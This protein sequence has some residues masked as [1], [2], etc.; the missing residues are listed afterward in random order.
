M[1]YHRRDRAAHLPLSALTFSL[2]SALASAAAVAQEGVVE[3]P[4]RLVLEHIVVTGEKVERSLRD[5][6]SSV[7]VIGE[8]ALNSLHHYSVS[9]V[10]AEVPNVV[11]TTGTVPN[12]RGVAGNG[13]AGGFNS[14]TGGAKA[15][16]S[17]LIDGVAEPFVADLTGDSGIWDI[18]QIEV[19]RGPQSTSNGRNSIGGMIYIK[20]NDPSLGEWDG[21]ARMGYRDQE[22][23]VDSA[24]MLN[25]PLLE[26]TLAVRVTAEKLDAQTL[27]DTAGFAGNPPDY[28]PNAIDTW[29]LKTKLLWAPNADFSALLA[30]SGNNEQGDTGRVFYTAD[31]P[32]EYKRSFFRNI[33]TDSDTV[34]LRLDYRLS[35][36]LS[37]DILAAAM[38]YQWGFEGYEADPALEQDVLFDESNVTLD[39]RMNLGREGDT[40]TGFAGLF[41]FERE[42]DFESTGAYLYVGDDESES[43]GVYGELTYA[44]SDRLRLTGGLRVEQEQQNRNFDYITFALANKLQNDKTITLPKLVLQYDLSD[45][46]TVGVSARKGYNAP[47]GA[48]AFATGEYYLF[49]EEEVN[50][51]EATL[52]SAFLKGA[53]SLSANLFYNDYEGYQALNSSRAITNMDEVETYGL[54]LQAQAT[55]WENL[56]LSAG[57]GLLE[58]EI[59]EP[60]DSYAN[61]AGNQLSTAPNVTGNLGLYYH[62]TDHFGAGIFAQYVDEYFGDLENTDERIAGD[63]TL[64][65]LTANYRSDAWSVSA[66]VNNVFDE[67]AITVREPPGRSAALG[68]AG[69]IDPRTYGVTVTFSFL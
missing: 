68:Y 5:T 63:Y 35:D 20:T 7:S 64:A 37:F 3:E 65:R 14:I 53:L 22:R 51:Y 13:S 34:S 57:L 60:G 21:A 17:T 24:V 66:Y 49:D 29:R 33:E 38:D 1:N 55:V 26:D 2:S 46:T 43:T 23:Y 58:T 47:G 12:I 32:F 25:A 27:T 16:V 67:E 6:T 40:L 41:Y 9:D 56:E 61:V 18:Q 42:Q 39:A 48:F 59:T 50:T 15:R 11:V 45:D 69:I 62:F 36:Y 4:Q 44:L 31:D 30:Y 19:Y 10:V 28:D 52:R 8:E 54:E